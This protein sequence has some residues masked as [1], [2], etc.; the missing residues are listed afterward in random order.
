MQV[1]I[2]GETPLQ[3]LSHSCII[4]P[5]NEGYTFQYSADGVNYTN[6]DSATPANENCM[7]VG[8]AYGSYIRLSGNASEVVINY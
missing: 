7:V 2:S 1:K 3:I 4:S 8:L 5:S 6:W